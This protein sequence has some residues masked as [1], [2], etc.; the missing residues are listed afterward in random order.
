MPECRHCL[1]EVSEAEAIRDGDNIFCCEACAAIY[2]FINDE[3]LDDFYSRR[4]TDDWQP[5]PPSGDTPTDPAAYADSIT[6]DAEMRVV[7]MSIEGIRCA[8]CVWLNEK[9]ISRLDGVINATVNYATHRARVKFDPAVIELGSV[10]QRIASIGYTPRPYRAD[11]AAQEARERTRDLLMRFGTAAFFSMQLMLY[12]AALYAG[13][14]EGMDAS[15][16]HTFRMISLALCTPVLFYS[17]WPFISASLRGL[18][19]LSLNMDVLVTLGAGSAYAY[20][21]YSMF[22]GGEVFF[23]TSAMIVTLV[24]LG[25]YIETAAKGRA[26]EAVARLLGLNPEE[27]LI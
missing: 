25:R 26:S 6:V 16:K 8:S 23:D 4:R 22:T 15:L 11:H 24:L 19:N 10:L 27:A 5:G 17:G 12:T 2:K 14:F 20:S 18:K 13:Y 9:L 1:L 7:D 3:G 21:I